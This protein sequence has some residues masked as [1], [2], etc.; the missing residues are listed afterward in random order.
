MAEPKMIDA[1]WLLEIVDWGRARGMSDADLFAKVLEA[2]RT[3]AV[4]EEGAK[5]YA[6]E[7]ETAEGE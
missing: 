7:G 5:Q 2:L 6:A 4:M 1:R 3:V